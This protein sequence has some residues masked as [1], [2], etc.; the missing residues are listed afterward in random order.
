MDTHTQSTTMTD[1]EQRQKTTDQ[2]RVNGANGYLFNHADKTWTTD[3]T[4]GGGGGLVALFNQTAL[5]NQSPFW[6]GC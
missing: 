2:H 6:A 5:F 1:G 3:D 4:K